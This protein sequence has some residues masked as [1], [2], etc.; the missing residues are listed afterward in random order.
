VRSGT[1]GFAALAETWVAHSLTLD[2]N[3]KKAFPFGDAAVTLF[4]DLLFG[5][6]RN[7]FFRYLKTKGNLFIARPLKG[8][9]PLLV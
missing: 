9:Y 6:C 7:Y 8:P 4:S 3:R 2:G 1:C 5:G